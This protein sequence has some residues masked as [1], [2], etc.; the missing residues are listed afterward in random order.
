EK[1]LGDVG[2]KNAQRIEDDLKNGKDPAA[3]LGTQSGPTFLG[4]PANTKNSVWDKAL[5]ELQ[6]AY[7]TRAYL[8]E[9]YETFEN[10]YNSAMEFEREMYESGELKED[11]WYREGMT[12]EEY[13]EARMDNYNMGLG[14]RG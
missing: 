12:F 13:L 3:W 5:R 10:Y 1:Q 8:K 7:S 4:H 6:R 2:G 14:G 11:S 9:W